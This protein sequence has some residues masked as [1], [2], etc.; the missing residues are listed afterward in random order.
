MRMNGIVS[1]ATGDYLGVEVD[2][3]ISPWILEVSTATSWISDDV[4]VGG[5]NISRII[6]ITKPVLLRAWGIS[7]IKHHTSRICMRKQCKL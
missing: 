4:V 5:W 7:G 6:F 1:Q 2:S 3:G